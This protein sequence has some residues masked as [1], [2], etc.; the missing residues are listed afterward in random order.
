MIPHSLLNPCTCMGFPVGLAVK[1]LSGM[2][3]MQVGTM[4]QEDHLEEEMTIHSNTLALEIPRIE[5]PGRLQSM[6]S[7]SWT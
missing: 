1:N 4:S 3:K 5:E 7:Q 6:G 2:Q